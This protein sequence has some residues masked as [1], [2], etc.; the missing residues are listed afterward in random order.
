MQLHP[1]YVN[2]CALH[3]TKKL[4]NLMCGTAEDAALKKKIPQCREV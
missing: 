1:A 2:T 4:N 3:V